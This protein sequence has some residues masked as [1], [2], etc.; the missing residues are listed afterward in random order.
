M[1]SPLRT[2]LLLAAVAALAACKTDSA[3]G[4]PAASDIGRP[5]EVEPVPQSSEEGQTEDTTT[6]HPGRPDGAVDPIRTPAPN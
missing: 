4:A 1:E 3:G 2:L 6:P 5:S